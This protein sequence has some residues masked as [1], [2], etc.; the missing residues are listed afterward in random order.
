MAST[1]EDSER[2][3]SSPLDE[4]EPDENQS[5]GGDDFELDE[6]D[7]VSALETSHG[8]I[9]TTSASEGVSHWASV[10]L[11]LQLKPLLGCSLV[12]VGVT[13][14]ADLAWL[15]GKGFQLATDGSIILTQPWGPARAGMQLVRSGGKDVALQ[16]APDAAQ[17]VIDQ[18]SMDT[19]LIFQLAPQALTAAEH[20][21][22]Q[23]LTQIAVAASLQREGQ[24]VLPEHVEF[25]NL[26]GAQAE[27]SIHIVNS[28]VQ[29]VLAALR[30]TLQ[31]PRSPLLT[32]KFLGVEARHSETKPWWPVGRLA[33]TLQRRYPQYE[34]LYANGQRNASLAK[35]MAAVDASADMYRGVLKEVREADK[36]RMEQLQNMESK[37]S[38]GGVLLSNKEALAQNCGR[39]DKVAQN[40]DLSVDELM[41]CAR[42]A[43]RRLKY[44]I[45]PNTEW[46][47]RD[48]NDLEV[49]GLDDPSRTVTDVGLCKGGAL[50]DPGVKQRKAAEQKQV[51]SGGL[52]NNVVDLSRVGMTFT[53]A[54]QFLLAVE[55]LQHT[56]DV[57]WVDNRFHHPYP[58]GYSDVTLGV[59][60]QLED[61]KDTKFICE[62]QLSLECMSRARQGWGWESQT[63]HDVFREC[64]VD[65]SHWSVLQALI[66]SELCMTYGEDEKAAICI[67]QSPDTTVETMLQIMSQYPGSEEV[68][69]VAISM[70]L[71]HLQNNQEHTCNAARAASAEASL[72]AAMTKHAAV[73]A[74]TVAAE[75]C[76]RLLGCSDLDNITN[77]T[78]H[79]AQE[80]R[81]QKCQIQSV[82]LQREA[83]VRDLCA[84]QRAAEVRQKKME[85][86]LAATQS[87]LTQKTEDS[88]RLRK[89]IHDSVS[90]DTNPDGLATAEL[91]MAR[92]TCMH[93][94][95]ETA[96][97]SLEI[98][99]L[100]SSV[101]RLQSGGE[102]ERLSALVEELQ[103]E[104]DRLKASA[105]ETENECERLRKEV[106]TRKPWDGPLKGTGVQ[107][108]QARP[109]LS[110]GYLAGIP[111]SGIISKKLPPLTR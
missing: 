1:Q 107:Q 75:E 31:D 84:L 96:E 78:R 21:I 74:I 54:E 95:N 55:K 27:Y 87:Q 10:C 33:A 76:L 48:M 57:C 42:E 40:A 8:A 88:K 99:S 16:S 72:L 93:L 25:L 61:D 17:A 7:G 85:E 110:P 47:D 30:K 44:S 60:V 105:E 37:C 65:A 19:T 36:E 92:V 108:F 49:C 46:A 58:D 28:S 63:T 6:P 79:A 69:V 82:S 56:L 20:K 59:N 70:V 24:V 11:C 14:E 111:E 64:G 71:R 86:E 77:G 104:M 39:C 100:K 81:R 43:Q 101:E 80:L 38:Y 51:V 53:T 67:L 18:V 98:E 90:K 35:I 29:G 91:Q 3:A 66:N 106:T 5:D 102:V 52:L 22:C 45:A 103:G 83:E 2:A 32:D 12:E 15:K 34:A 26:H 13:N 62:I 9:V 4:F 109:F 89:M 50:F 97:K 73:E 41:Q 23:D 68:N 94:R